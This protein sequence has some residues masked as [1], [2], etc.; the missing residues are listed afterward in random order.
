[1]PV[2]VDTYHGPTVMGHSSQ[3]SQGQKSTPLRPPP[4]VD[5]EGSWVAEPKRKVKTDFANIINLWK[6]DSAEDSQDHHFCC[7]GCL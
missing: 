2:G 5:T 4:S 7:P 1:M 6:T 3:D